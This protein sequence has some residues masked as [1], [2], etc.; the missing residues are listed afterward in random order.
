M[1]QRNPENAVENAVENAKAYYHQGKLASAAALCQEAI[2]LNP[3]CYPAY[4]TLGEILLVEGKI[5]QGIRAHT[6][7]IALEPE[8][9]RANSYWQLGNL[10]AEIEEF[11][12]AIACYIQALQRQPDFA[13]VYRDLGN[14]L[15]KLGLNEE[16]S[17][18]HRQKLPL[19]LLVQFS[20]SA[21]D[22]ATSC[23]Y[24]QRHKMTHI[25]I[26]PPG[27]LYLSPPKTPDG[28]VIGHFRLSE[29]ELSET[30][31]GVLENAR[32][33]A[34][35][36]TIAVFTSENKLFKK[37]SSG[38]FE[39][40]A[41]SPHLPPPHKLDG[42]VAFLSVRW[43]STYFHWLSDLLPRIELLRLSGMDI[44]DIDFF[45]V[46]CHDLSFQKET[47]S[48]LG[49]PNN[50]IIPSSQ[51]P[52]IQAERLAIPFLHY[53]GG[54][55]VADFLRRE[56]LPKSEIEEFSETPRF[57]LGRSQHIYIS[58]SQAG[59][60]RIVNEE[61]LIDALTLL[62]FQAIVLESMPFSEQVATLAAA[63]V[64]VAPHGGGLTNLAFCRP[65]TKVVEIFSPDYIN[66]CYWLLGHQVGIEY[67]YFLGE[68]LEAKETDSPEQNRGDR[69]I[70]VDVPSLLELLEFAGV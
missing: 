8:P 42:T 55:W 10:L 4:K 13:P 9:E 2:K 14:T 30:F 28:K 11:Y 41:S 54:Q 45:V 61:K 15:S 22:W 6:R 50:K 24:P 17:K 37:V 56:F 63:Q 7:A 62:G 65:G 16:A 38:N 46:N 53:R 67:Y 32:A 60:R 29:F 58:R 70:W 57:S 12:G 47:L 66:G 25:P 19:N 48:Q 69:D 44:G 1:K 26:H 18:C 49:I 3:D 39:L 23:Q 20:Q 31:V 21:K 40:I 35:Y 33:W 68:T 64:V 59:M 5:K 52:H 36:Y 27:K 34:D 51:F 43:G